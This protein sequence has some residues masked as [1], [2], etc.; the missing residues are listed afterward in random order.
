MHTDVRNTDLQGMVDLLQEQHV[1]KIDVVL[2]ATR[3]TP[4]DG[5]III[6]GVAHLIEDDGV[7]DPNG[8]YVPTRVFD[9]GVSEKLGIPL[10]Y[11]RRLRDNRPDLWDAN[12]AGWLHGSDDGIGPDSRS[13]LF[14]G[15]RGDL[16][17][18]G[19]ARALLSDRFGINDNL[20][21]LL[22]VLDGVRAAGVEAVVDRASL[23][24]RRMSVD[25]VA[26]EVEVLAEK[27]L[28]G[29]RNPFGDDFERWRRVADREGL[30]Y[31]GEEPVIWAGLGISNSETGDG[32]FTIVP[33]AKIKVCANGLT[34]TKDMIRNVHLGGRLEDGV[35]SWS[36]D[37]Q[38]VNIDLVRR[39]T[40]DAVATFLNHDYLQATVDELTANGERGVDDHEEVKAIV[41]RAKYTDA[42]ADDI[43]KFFTRGGQMTRAGVMNA[44]TAAAQMTD[45]ADT[46][47]D[48]EQRAV[49]LLTV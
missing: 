30:G 10:T 14:R 42:Q 24:E 15:F 17:D 49:S 8:L 19:I 27:M 31:G 13:F 22:A 32:A 35:V 29:Y 39:K 1:R 43:L 9:E 18:A 11:V 4:S 37:T 34:I 12:V 25:I 33:K 20:D 23:T 21:V 45:N 16:D 47:F 6:S 48:M 26:P 46:A 40:A 36:E 5:S 3:M 2:P 44:A 41:K 38:R 7:T 28:K